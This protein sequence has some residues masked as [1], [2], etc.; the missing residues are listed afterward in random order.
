MSKPAD[1]I[2]QLCPN[3]GLCCNG[4][5]FADVELQPGD[6]DGR[7]IDLGMSLKKK[8]MK[9]AFAQPCRCFDGKLCNI[10]ADRPKRCAT[11]E[12]G[13]L[14][15]VQSGAMTAPAALKHIADAKKLVEKVRRVL[16]RL[17]DDDEQLALTKRYRRMMAKP[18]DLSAGKDNGAARGEL[19]LAVNDLMI[20][21]QHD[22]LK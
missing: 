18:I 11:F 5:L 22:F 10:Y 2:S 7:L 9:R 17:G 8:G 19:M 16:H 6:D 21:L 4:V 1:A 20:D 3:C 12:C 13:L 14:K 15:R